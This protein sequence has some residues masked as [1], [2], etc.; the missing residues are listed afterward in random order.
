MAYIKQTYGSVMKFVITER[1][2]WG[3]GDPENIRPCG[4]PFEF[5]G[6]VNARGNW[7]RI[8]VLILVIP[9]DLK[10]LYNDWPYGVEDGIVHL[11]VW[12]KFELSEN[13]ATGDL[14]DAMRKQIDDFVEKTFRSRIPSDRVRI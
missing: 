13:P 9:D 8:I 1:L 5:A 10:I 3:D 4:R 11:V 14:T 12:T 2:R 7:Q 6:K